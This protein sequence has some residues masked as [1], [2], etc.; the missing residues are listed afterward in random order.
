MEIKF[1]FFG[2]DDFSI[3]VLD[4]LKKAG[5][6]PALVVTAPDRPKGR[7]LKLAP[8]QVKAWSQE[9]RIRCLQPEKLDSGLHSTLNAVRYT[10]F[11][12][13]SYGLIVPQNVL[14]I[15]KHG[16]LNVHPSLLPKYRG[17]TP[18]ESQI[19]A[20]EKEVGVTIMLMDEK[21]DH[22]PIV[23]QKKLTLEEIQNAT[24]LQ[25]RLAHLGGEMLSEA[26]PK[27]VKGKIEAKPQN[28]SQATYTK[29]FIKVDG[30]IN[31]NDE[32]YKNFLKIQAF[33]S[34]FF[35]EVGA[36]KRGLHAET[37]R[38]KRIR[39]LVKSAEYKDGKLRVLRVLPEG[40]REMSYGEFLRGLR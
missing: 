40:R 33:D 5:L 8:P 2:S 38:R 10:L 25:R 6:I 15:P 27:W 9:N 3:A 22:G 39:V 34:Y 11:I 28:H 13:A 24:K 18:I 20:D 4:E 12:V 29:K 14:D 17:P 23:M 1:V 36:D 26:V 21:M 35:T 37:R 19:L 30:E 32:P 16:T 7:G 31:L